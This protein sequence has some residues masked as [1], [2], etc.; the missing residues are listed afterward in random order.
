MQ[1]INKKANFN[2]KLFER[3]EAG[4]VLSGSEAKT[5]RIRGGNLTNAYARINNGQAYLVN[6]SIPIENKKDHDPT[7]SRKI[8]LHKSEIV[9]LGTKMRSQGLLLVP[10]KLY[11]KHRLYKLELALAKAKRK[12]EKRESVKKKDVE[13]DIQYQLK[14]SNK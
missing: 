14:D 1:I 8:L 11:N 6:F 9:S 3:I 7:R 12:F 4:I 13:R 10:V 5:L 2:Y